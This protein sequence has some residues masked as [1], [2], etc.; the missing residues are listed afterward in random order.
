VFTWAERQA[1]RL[2][3]AMRAAAKRVERKVSFVM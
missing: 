1:N 3:P 2:V